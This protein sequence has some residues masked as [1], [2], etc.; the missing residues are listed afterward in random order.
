M[1]KKDR[2]NYEA[3]ETRIWQKVKN[4]NRQNA[5]FLQSQVKE[6]E[7]AKVKRMNI[8]EFLMNKQK[9]KEISSHGKGGS[10]VGSVHSGVF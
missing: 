7:D 10:G 9:L 4:I 3:E 5:D 2:E 6:K 1:W 8:N